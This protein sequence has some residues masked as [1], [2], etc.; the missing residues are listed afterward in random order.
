MFLLD[1]T[2]PSGVPRS[3]KQ[4]VPVVTQAAVGA[5]HW[6]ASRQGSGPWPSGPARPAQAL[7]A[8]GLGTEAP[9]QAEALGE[10]QRQKDLLRER[11]LRAAAGRTP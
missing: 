2:R 7:M 3:M 9:T 1:G 10:H 8:W 11:G 5:G 4:V 6:A